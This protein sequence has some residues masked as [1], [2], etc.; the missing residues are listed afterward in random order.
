MSNHDSIKCTAPELGANLLSY[1]LGSLSDFDSA[2]FEE[3]LLQCPAC[4]TELAGSSQAL[5]ALSSKRTELVQKWKA[6]AEDF[7]S[8]H[9]ATKKDPVE[10]E[11]L[12]SGRPT[13]QSYVWVSV[14]AACMIAFVF[15]FARPQPDEVISHSIPVDTSS[16]ITTRRDSSVTPVEIDS[17]LINQDSIST[18][19]VRPLAT[20][21]PLAFVFVNPR[22][23]A[24]SPP[25]GFEEAMRKYVAKD[26]HGAAAALAEVAIASPYNPETL[27]YLGISQY[28]SGSYASAVKTFD[29]AE[30]LGLRTTRLA[31][32][33]WYR[34]NCRLALNE[35]DKALSDLK[36]VAGTN[37]DDSVEAQQLIIRLGRASGID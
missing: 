34:A 30:R 11:A 10:G 22:G 16:T 7:E 20:K 29:N 8:R 26:Y 37:T 4:Q 31:Q 18:R 13:R 5:K 15:W 24:V 12:Q 14:A 27:L 21:L 35:P 6:T 36:L 1:G 3:H 19:D 23:E 9:A 33:R 2:A 25:V 28:L 17:S 32:I